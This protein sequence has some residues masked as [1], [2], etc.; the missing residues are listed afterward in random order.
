MGRA[1]A[2]FASTLCLLAGMTSLAI[3]KDGRGD[4]D[5]DDRH[6]SGIERIEKNIIGKVL[7]SDY[8]GFNDDLLT[9]GLGATGLAGSVPPKVA[10]AASPTPEELRRLAIYNNY[11]ALV[12]VSP[13]GGYGILYGP[14]AGAEGKAADRDGKVAGTEYLALLDGRDDGNPRTTVALQV[15][16][17]FDPANACMVTATSSGSRGVYGAIGTSG[18]WGLKKGCAVVYTDKGTGTGFFDLENG[19]G[20]TL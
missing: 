14:M 8:D 20:Y 5:R 3:A 15:P 16:E 18:E 19:K 2:T 4:D 17:T 1:A 10:N 13:G 11:R 12:D 7:R 6:D 9:G